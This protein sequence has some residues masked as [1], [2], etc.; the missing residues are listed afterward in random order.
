MIV[1]GAMVLTAMLVVEALPRR[2]DRGRGPPHR[3]VTGCDRSGIAVAACPVGRSVWTPDELRRPTAPAAGTSSGWGGSAPS[4][5]A[6]AGPT[7]EAG[8]TRR[9]TGAP[10][11]PVTA[12]ATSSGR[13]AASGGALPAVRRRGTHA[14]PPVRR[15]AHPG[16]VPPP[17][18]ARGR[19]GRR[20]GSRGDRPGRAGVVAGIGGYLLVV[21]GDDRPA[22]NAPPPMG[23]RRRRGAPRA[24]GR[25]GPG[26]GGGPPGRRRV[27]AVAPP[28]ETVNGSAVRYDAAN[29]GDGRPRT[30]WRM[31]GDGTGITLT[32]DLRGDRDHRGRPD[33]RLCQVDG[34]G[35][36]V[37]RQPPDHRVEWEFDDGTRVAQDLA[38]PA[39]P[40]ARPTSIPC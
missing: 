13:P 30:A 3:G 19:A 10:A 35:Q 4:A 26:R 20:P 39:D 17:P 16:P 24:R 31:A 32:L 9:A 40:A 15:R 6:G 12:P 5:E 37:P 7:P 8:P 2:Q 33:Q 28:I 25:A 38:E 29:M 1:G 34:T 36:L 22:S 21:A 18:T 14:R 11:S 23:H 27:P